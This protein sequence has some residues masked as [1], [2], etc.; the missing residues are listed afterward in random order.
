MLDSRYLAGGLLYETEEEVGAAGM[1]LYG[2]SSIVGIQDIDGSGNPAFLTGAG[3]GYV[4]AVSANERNLV[5]SMGFSAAASKPRVLPPI[6]CPG[7][8]EVIRISMVRF[9]FS[10]ATTPSM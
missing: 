2:A 8:T 7:V 5:W 6:S 9:S 10:P 3:D 4:Y 1:V